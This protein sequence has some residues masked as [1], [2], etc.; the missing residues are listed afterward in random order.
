[1]RIIPPSILDLSGLGVC[2]VRI[3]QKSDP[4][5]LNHCHYQGKCSSSSRHRG[6]GAPTEPSSFHLLKKSTIA[7]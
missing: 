1:M 4:E 7:R 3:Y 6:S 2:G 5:L